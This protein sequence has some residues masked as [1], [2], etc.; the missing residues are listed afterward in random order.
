MRLSSSA[1]LCT[2]PACK[3]DS[4]RGDKEREATFTLRRPHP[5][6]HSRGHKQGERRD[7]SPH[8]RILRYRPSPLM[9]DCQA[10]NTVMP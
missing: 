9:G 3:P 1:T 5:S 2:T 7:D 10:A 4:S 6:D 8:Y